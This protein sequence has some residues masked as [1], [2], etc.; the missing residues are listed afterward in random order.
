M[1][2]ERNV[3]NLFQGKPAEADGCADPAT[4][5]LTGQNSPAQR[6][7]IAAQAPVAH[8]AALIETL[9]LEHRGL[10]ALYGEVKRAGS[11]RRLGRRRALHLQA[12]REA[13]QDHL[14]KEAVG[15]YIY[16]LQRHVA[17]AV[18][19]DLTCAFR[20]EMDEIGRSLFSFIIA[21]QRIADDLQQQLTVHHKVQATGF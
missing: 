5:G 17:D 2:A 18:S 15:L 10:L 8:S 4:L 16:L 14:I 7:A 3:V 9:V 20:G 21:R 13:L 6:A 12:F 1:N 11:A 19:Y